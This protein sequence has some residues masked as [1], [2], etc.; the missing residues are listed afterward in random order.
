MR[1][2]RAARP[3]LTPVP[4][5]VLVT[6]EVK[7]ADTVEGPIPPR[8]DSDEWPGKIHTRIQDVV[9]AKGPAPWSVS[10]IKDERNNVTLIAN[11]PGSGNIPHWHK[12]FDEWWIVMRGTL[13][14]H[15]TGG[16]T[17]TATEGDVVWVPR[18][19]VHHIQNVGDGLSLRLAVSQPPAEHYSSPCNVCDYA[20]DAAPVFG[21]ADVIAPGSLT[22]TDT[23][24]EPIPPRIDNTDWPGVLHT[25]IEAIQAKHAGEK[26][27]HEFIVSD[28]RNIATL[29]AHPEG[30]G[31]DP[32][33]HKDFD[34]WWYVA[35]GQI[36]WELSGGKTFVASKGDN[37]WV[38]RG[39][40]H[41]ITTEGK[42]TSIRLAIAMPPGGHWSARCDVCGKEKSDQEVSWMDVPKTNEQLSG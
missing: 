26:E 38:P 14:W 17:V 22:I 25:S 37:V 30:R 1:S 5:N 33:Y 13:Q 19:A 29:L 32:H 28:E 7:I 20:P 9:D 2:Q 6:S 4:E 10:L 36:R 21:I 24:E 42:E 31:N 15:Y 16:K 18:G 23:V 27:W 8:V 34:E 35:A 40:T 3:C 11:D 12:D 41:H 39:T